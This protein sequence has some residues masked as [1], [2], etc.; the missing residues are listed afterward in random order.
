M[1]RLIVAER[2]ITELKEAFDAAG[3]QL[4]H[5]HS[6][7][8]TNRSGPQYRDSPHSPFVGI[9]DGERFRAAEQRQLSIRPGRAGSH[10]DGMPPFSDPTPMRVDALTRLLRGAAEP[11][12]SAGKE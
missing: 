9:V 5:R 11:D 10:G 6:A 12:W 7:L 3:C 2:L 4:G 8:G 1:E